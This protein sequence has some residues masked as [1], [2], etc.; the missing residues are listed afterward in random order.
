M[1]N[2][3]GVEFPSKKSFERFM[4]IGPSV[5]KSLVCGTSTLFKPDF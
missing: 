1:V 5:G 3:Y 2:V 4:G